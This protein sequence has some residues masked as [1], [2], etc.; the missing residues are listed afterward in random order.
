MR[1]RV[2]HEQASPYATK[3]DVKEIVTEAFENFAQIMK[4][5][6]DDV[7]MRFD[8]VDARMN[9][10]VENEFLPFKRDTEQSFYE[11]RADMGHVKSRLGKV[12]GGLVITNAK[13]DE[14]IDVVRG[15]EARITHLERHIA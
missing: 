10:F 8:M 15:H 1:P 11:L 12:E 13:L 14:V 3:A 4:R 2:Q 9:S 7:Y 5:S 6:F